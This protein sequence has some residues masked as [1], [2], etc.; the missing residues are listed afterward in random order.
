M[1]SQHALLLLGSS[2]SLIPPS[3]YLRSL[4]QPPQRSAAVGFGGR[5]RISAW[6]G[7]QKAAAGFGETTEEVMEL[8]RKVLAQTYA[9]APVVL[10]RGKGCKVYD[11]EGREYLDMGVGVSS[12]GH[13]DPDLLK[14]LQEQVHIL[15]DSSG[16]C[17]I[18]ELK[19]AKRL[20]ECSFADCVFFS[21]SGIE[22][23]K[24]AIEFARKFQIFSQPDVKLPATEFI[25]FTNSFHGR[26]LGSLALTSKENYRS[27]FEPVMPGVTFMEYG[28]IEMVKNAIQ[29]GK[30]AAV[31]V[32][33]VQGEGGIY[34]ATKEFLQALRSACDDAGALLIFDEV[35][36][37]MGRSGY[38][39]AHEAYSVFPDIMTLGKPLAGGLPIGAVLTTESVAA[40]ISSGHHG[41]TFAGGPLFCRAALVVLDKIQNPEFLASVSKKGQYLKELLLDKLVGNPHLKEVRG[42]GLL[43]GVELDVSSSPL[44]DACRNSGLLTAASAAGKENVVRLA[45]ALVISEQE[46][47]L[48]AAII[49]ESMASLD[50]NILV[51]VPTH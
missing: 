40:A 4:K 49:S 32:E 46:L 18:P 11:A 37:G 38:L 19:L 3:R 7:S 20:M 36:S 42:L 48:A 23:N 41:E 16:F 47:E 17:S 29:P 25:A 43:V 1:S 9:R 24:V 12:L 34:S 33:L 28:N 6:L 2:I 26:T 8:E 13:A 27:P 5:N 39:W 30:T 31:F 45:P 14:A 35:Q 44:V 10:V 15:T 21:N 51:G 50:G 22:A